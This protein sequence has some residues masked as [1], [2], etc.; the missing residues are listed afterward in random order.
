MDR[1]G[2]DCGGRAAD[3]FD[4]RTL[5]LLK[6]VFIA[7]KLKLLKLLLLFSFAQAVIYNFSELRA[8]I[9]GHHR[10]VWGDGSFITQRTA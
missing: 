8:S 6:H 5:C 9:F 3:R 2:G 4:H 10:R 1:D 7:G